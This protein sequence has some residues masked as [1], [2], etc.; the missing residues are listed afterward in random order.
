M[1]V[2]CQ[3]LWSSFWSK[4]LLYRVI[5]TYRYL[6]NGC[7]CTWVAIIRKYW[8][9]WYTGNFSIS[10]SHVNPTRDTTTRLWKCWEVYV[11]RIWT[12][13]K[14]H[15]F[16]IPKEIRMIKKTAQ[17]K[18]MENSWGQPSITITCD[19][20]ILEDVTSPTCVSHK[21]VC[22]RKRNSKA[23]QYEDKET[24]QMDLKC[25]SGTDK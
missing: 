6:G 9:L 20:V 12:H 21:C 10:K 4:C 8:Q 5:A 13:Q 16:L 3:V 24:K 19:T 1:L 17:T 11:W 15:R 18:H 22:F 23:I 7:R 14:Q 2:R 25:S